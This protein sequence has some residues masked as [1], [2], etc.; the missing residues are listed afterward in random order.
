MCD[1]AAVKNIYYGGVIIKRVKNIAIFFLLTAFTLCGCSPSEYQQSFFAMDTYMTLTVYG[2]NAEQ[3]VE[4]ARESIYEFEKMLSVTDEES[5]I[6]KIN[7]SNGEAVVVS[8]ETAEIIE[9]SLKISSETDGAFDLTIYPVLSL[10][11]FTKNENNV[12]DKKE[13]DALLESIDYN[14]VELDGNSVTVPE[15]VMIDLG[16][17]GKGFVGDKT[18]EQLKAQG[19]KSALL[20][21][22]GN[23]QAV[24]SKPD[25]ADWKIGL[26]S[27]IDDG[28]LGVLSIS[29]LA[30]V[31]SGNY[32]R[33]FIDD[34]GIKYGHIINPDTGYPVEND[35]LSVTIIGKEGKRCDALSTA[36]FVMGYEKAVEFWKEN[37]DFNMLLVKNNGEIHA[38]PGA[39]MIFKT[40][41]DVIII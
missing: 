5:E 7:N 27:P 18:A 39:S 6:Y 24:G 4:L 21:I 3:A 32:E 2:D 37:N 9:Y 1:I 30:V 13:I 36:L 25:G 28:V 10:W 16:A 11:G 23:I 26:R 40:E 15:K 34:N 17:I 29:D 22:G 31:T 14:Q 33:Y 41:F 12:P 35:L 19:V 20:D 8:D 38:T